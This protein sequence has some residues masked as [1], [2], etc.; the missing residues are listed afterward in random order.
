M[1]PHE[2]IVYQ[3]FI[4]MLLGISFARALRNS[5]EGLSAIKIIAFTLAFGIIYGILDEF[6]EFFV[7]GR[8]ASG[9]DV[10]ID[11]A[12]TLFG[13]LIYYGKNKAL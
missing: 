9:F 6:H 2:A 1:F 11:S 10:F 7:P 13:S 12:G 5:F 4:Y 3:S 8:S